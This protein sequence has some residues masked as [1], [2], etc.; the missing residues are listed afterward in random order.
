MPFSSSVKTLAL[1]ALLVTAGC[2]GKTQQASRQSKDVTCTVGTVRV[3][4][5]PNYVPATGSLQA[6]Q[7]V[8]IST[9]MM[10]WVKKIH[11]TEGQTVVKGDPLLTIDDS[12]L[13]AKKAQAE[14]GLAEAHAVLA[15]AE[16]MAERFENLYAEKAVSRQQL[17][18]VLTG[19]DRAAAG[20]K[21][22]E[23]A[24]REV[25]V[26]LGYLDIKAP[27]DGLVARK[28]IEAGN[29]ASPGMP[30]LILEQ[31][32]QMKVVAHV[33][34]K[35]VSSVRAGDFVTV[36]VTS[37]AGAVYEVPLAR[38]IPTANP[39]SRTYDI[40]AY[41]P[42]PDGRLK[43]GMFARVKVTV[44][45]RDAVLAP[46][47]AIIERG[48]LKG[49]WTVDIDGIIALRWIRLG[50]P[51]GDDIEIL[52]GLAGGETIVLSFDQPLAEGDRVVR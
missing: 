32:Q 8:M 46:A 30:L 17:D 31:T 3:E 7:S 18:D 27:T 21:M 25:N 50:H 4:N 24:V 45:S 49:V 44:G 19:R 5:V 37:L 12:D 40:E 9:R 47:E 26:H 1:I 34:E 11:V 28:M 33:G 20:V 52:A 38:V 6:D 39:G 2:S 10:G 41:V 13:R 29:M 23:A 15:N 35:D 14:A 42:N 22:A 16:R 48:Q 36:D 43:S 51:R